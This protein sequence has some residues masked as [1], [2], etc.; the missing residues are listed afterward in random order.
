M[1]LLIQATRPTNSVMPQKGYEVDAG[2]GLCC[3]AI[4]QIV[5]RR[6]SRWRLWVM[7]G[8]P[9]LGKDFLRIGKLAVTCGHVSGL[10]ARP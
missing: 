10:L 1:S 9:P 4:E 3:S 8:W 7:C 6:Y 2:R 5:S